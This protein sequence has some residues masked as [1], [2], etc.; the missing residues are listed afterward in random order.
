MTLGLILYVPRKRI[1]GEF[2]PFQPAQLNS[3][4]HLQITTKFWRKLQG[5]ALY[6][7]INIL[8][9]ESVNIALQLQFLDVL[10]GSFSL[11]ADKIL[12]TY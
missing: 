12:F 6:W 3:S 1:T 7:L 11:N 4:V 8:F 2:F 10:P 5:V 9:V